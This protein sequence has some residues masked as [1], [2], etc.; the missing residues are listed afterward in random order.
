LKGPQ[1]ASNKDNRLLAADMSPD[2]P[3]ARKRFLQQLAGP[4][5][6][7]PAYEPGDAP[8]EIPTRILNPQ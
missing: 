6:L 1:G 5:V 7:A 2:E 4:D 3:S 8:L